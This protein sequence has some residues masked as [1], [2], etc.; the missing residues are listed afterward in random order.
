MADPAGALGQYPNRLVSC[1]RP[2]P[3]IDPIEAFVAASN[4]EART[5]WLQPSSGKAMVGIGSAAELAGDFQRAAAAWR[6]MLAAA[7]VEAADGIGPR[8]LGGFC[9][10]PQALSSALWDGFGTGRLV[11][12]ERMLTIRGGAAWLTTNHR[13]G[14]HSEPRKLATTPPRVGLAPEAWKALVGDVARG[15]GNTRLGATK[16]VLART[17]QV[18]VQKPMATILRSL[19]ADYQAC[20]I[21]AIAAGDACFLGATPERLVSLHDGTATTMALAGS[22]PRGSTPEQD[23]VLGDRLLADPKER[24]EHAVVVEALRDGLA[25]VSTRVVADAEPRLHRLA[26]LQHLMTPIR[27]QVRAGRGVLDLV[28]RLHPT[29]AVGGYPRQRALELIRD[30]EGLD[31]GWYAAPMGWVDGQG[32]GEFVVGLRSA[33]LRD[34][35]ATLFTGCGIVAD[36][37]PATELAESGWKLRPILSALGAAE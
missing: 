26:N 24:A 15:I 30:R 27:A 28:E 7:R 11:L 18:S 20:T 16:V 9:F 2:T 23:R 25:E 33:L 17:C 3:L 36:S 31:R 13:A 34:N 10:D 35:L 22:G 8:L 1:T 19:A 12:P 37:D 4:T 14:T 21:F 29:P 6:G 5:L 32:Q